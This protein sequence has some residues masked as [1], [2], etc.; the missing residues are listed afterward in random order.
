MTKFY[1]LPDTSF[2]QMFGAV[3][4]TPDK[5][6]VI[7]GGTM[8]D[9]PQLAGFLKERC[10]AHVDAWLL[11]HAH[12]DHIGALWGVLREHPEIS[13]DRIYLHFPARTDLMAC[14]SWLKEEPD[15]WRFFFDTME[16]GDPRF[17]TVKRGDT[18]RVDDVTVT[19]MRTYNPEIR[20]NYINNSSTVYRIQ[21][22]KASVLI[23]GDL[24]V[25]AGEET[26]ALCAAEELQTDY[27]QM[28]HHGQSG[29]SRAFY[30][31][32]RPNRCIWPTPAWLWDNDKGGGFD[33]GPWQTVRTRE[34]MAELGVTEHFVEK[35]GISEI[36]I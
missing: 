2:C 8:W 23:L 3:I 21:G 13:V 27:T 5:T 26:M 19:V 16:G 9:A 35:D 14:H 22:P 25:E 6:L 7:D 12:H 11:T 34:W 32:I 24:G 10:S 20:A 17:V 1:L 15:I 4:R 36:E 31:Y 30:E 29:V 33:T 18:F 28:A